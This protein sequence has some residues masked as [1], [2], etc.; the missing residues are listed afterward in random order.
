[1]EQNVKWIKCTGT[2]G[3]E[4]TLKPMWAKQYPSHKKKNYRCLKKP[5]KEQLD[6]KYIG[7]T[8]SSWNSPAFVI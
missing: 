7:Q 6:A 3:E 1:M 5:L 2:E 4:R 8:A